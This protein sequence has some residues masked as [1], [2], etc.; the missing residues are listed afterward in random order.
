MNYQEADDHFYLQIEADNRQWLEEV[1]PYVTPGL[2]AQ[3][4]LQA[5]QRYVT[6]PPG[7][8]ETVE[9]RMELAHRV[10]LDVAED[11]D[12]QLPDGNFDN[13]ACAWA[14]ELA[15]PVVFCVLDMG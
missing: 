15:A 5:Y 14:Y 12:L 4:I 10:L 6:T 8:P 7:E 1:A 9:S 3:Q 2:N 13:M 11:H